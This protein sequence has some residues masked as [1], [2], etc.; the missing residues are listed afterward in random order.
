MNADTKIK[1]MQALNQYA[2]DARPKKE[3]K[4]INDYSPKDGFDGVLINVEGLLEEDSFIEKSNAEKE[5]SFVKIKDDPRITRV[6]KF[7]RNTSIDEL[8]QLINVL[9]GDMSIVGNRPIPLYEAELLT[10]DD[11]VE[12]CIAPA[13]LTGLWQV[14]KR[15][16]STEMLPAERKMLDNQYARSY[17]FWL[18]IRIIIRTFKALFQSETV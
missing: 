11:W 18:D 5:I 10:T 16:K 13:G 9:K 8:P 12:R 6:G 14:E 17:N 4:F 1:A 15:G 2:A 7:I 3:V